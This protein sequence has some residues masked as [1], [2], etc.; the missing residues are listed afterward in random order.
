MA[1]N[2]AAREAMAEDL[3]VVVTIPRGVASSFPSNQPRTP[4]SL[5]KQE[6]HS[7][8]NS[9]DNNYN[10]TNN[11]GPASIRQRD[12]AATRNPAEGGQ[13]PVGGGVAAV[14]SSSLVSAC[15]ADWQEHYKK[16]RVAN[17]M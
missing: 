7:N 9:N 14:G 5:H 3:M 6:D 17:E 15:S 12:R 11:T 8:D 2:K 10:N 4:R 16:K 13:F 1:K